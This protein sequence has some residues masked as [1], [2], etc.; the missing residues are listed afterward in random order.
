MAGNPDDP[1]V[2]PDQITIYCNTAEAKFKNDTN[3]SSLD[4]TDPRFL[5]ATSA[6]NKQGAILVR[7]RWGDRELRLSILREEDR[8]N[9]SLSYPKR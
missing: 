7:V 6:A 5:L 8:R 4:T 3:I 1:E 2:T 9:H